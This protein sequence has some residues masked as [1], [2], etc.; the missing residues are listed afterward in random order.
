ME[1]TL[2]NGYVTMLVM[3][4]GTSKCCSKTFIKD[5]MKHRDK[6]CIEAW[7]ADVVLT[8]LHHDDCKRDGETGDAAHEGSCSYEGKRPRIHPGPGAGG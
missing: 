4:V 8:D 1:Y 6:A 3:P 7:K 2:F 5:Y